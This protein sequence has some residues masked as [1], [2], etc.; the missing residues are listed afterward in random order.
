VGKAFS[1]GP[2]KAVIAQRLLGLT[3]TLEIGHGA[4]YCAQRA[5][6]REESTMKLTFLGSSSKDGECPT[7]YATDRDTYVIQGWRVTDADALATL[8]IPDH[9]TAIEVPRALLG[10]APPNPA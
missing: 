8:D 3:T 2:L 5:G 9:E 7:L 4:S 6:H 1:D 10:F